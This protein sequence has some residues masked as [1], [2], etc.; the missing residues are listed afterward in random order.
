MVKR[1]EFLKQAKDFAEEGR[2]TFVNFSSTAE[3]AT[4]VFAYGTRWNCEQVWIDQARG[5][6]AYEY[7]PEGRVV[8]PYN[9]VEEKVSFLPGWKD[10]TLIIYF[11]G[12]EIAQISDD[13]GRASIPNLKKVN[14]LL[15]KCKSKQEC[16]DAFQKFL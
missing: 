16:L 13:W 9:H 2:Y 10:T 12:E 4:P 8:L 15:Q 14:N 3:V 5:I 7:S 11:L 6:A 1:I